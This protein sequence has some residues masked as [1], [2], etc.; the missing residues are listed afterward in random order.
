MADI[1]TITVEGNNYDVQ[2]LT[3]EIKN[4]IV[5]IQKLDAV[6]KVH[7]DKIATLQL[8]VDAVQ[9]TRTRIYEILVSLLK[10]IP[11]LAETQGEAE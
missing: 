3:D 8:T 6:L 5:D 7:S 4:A 10:D 11:V 9:Q 1:K 2:D